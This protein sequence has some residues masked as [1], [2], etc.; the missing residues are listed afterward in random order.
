MPASAR[1]EKE[2][3]RVRDRVGPVA[4][5]AAHAIWEASHGTA[6]LAPVNE[7]VA[8]S[9]G[10]YIEGYAAERG[11][12]PDR[13]YLEVHEGHMMYLKPGEEAFVVPELIPLLQRWFRVIFLNRFCS[14]SVERHADQGRMD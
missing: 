1:G 3:E 10:D 7:D 6:T 4:A 14:E 5:V 11:S 9:F 2:S 8:K 13:R 12:P